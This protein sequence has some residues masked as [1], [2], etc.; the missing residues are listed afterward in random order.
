MIIFPL[1]GTGIVGTKLNTRAALVTAPDFKF[2]A[3]IVPWPKVSA[4]FLP[5]SAAGATP[6]PAL[7]TVK[8]LAADVVVAVTLNSG[9][10]AKSFGPFVLV[11]VKVL[12]DPLGVPAA[13]QEVVG[14][15][16]ETW[17]AATATLL[18]PVQ[19]HS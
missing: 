1:T 6:A 19:V 2:A 17:G 11:T 12:P 16:H 8:L 14:L 18:A 10:V 4:N 7:S 9:A 15:V 13:G 5:P 3:L